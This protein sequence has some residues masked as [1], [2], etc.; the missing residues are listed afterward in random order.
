MH[1]GDGRWNGVAVLS[2]VG[3]SDVRYGLD[4]QPAFEEAVEPR[5]LGVTC[6]G[7]RLWSLYVPNGRSVGSPHYAYKLAFIDALREQVRAEADR[8]PFAL[9]GD[10]NVA[11]HDDDVWDIGL[12]AESTHVTAAERAAVEAVA[13]AAG[14]PLLDLM[15]RASVDPDDERHPYTFWEH[16]ML[17]FQK[18]RGMRIDLVL[19]NAALRARVR[20]VWVD[21]DARRG[22][23]PSDHAPIVVDLTDGTPSA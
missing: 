17:G 4:A 15:P 3:L 20:D 22:Q 7:L 1:L 23:G 19:A 13:Q 11:P 14:D 21:R 10:F 16:R 2:R 12:F 6:G 8:G 9:L 5:A 18:G